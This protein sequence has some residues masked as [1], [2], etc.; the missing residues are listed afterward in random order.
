M[1][2]AHLPRDGFEASR[3]ERAH[4]RLVVARTGH[5]SPTQP[6]FPAPSASRPAAGGGEV[7]FVHPLQ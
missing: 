2:E 7:L 5:P 3:Q 4:V 6:A 1:P